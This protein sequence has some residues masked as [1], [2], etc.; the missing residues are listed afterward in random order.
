MHAFDLESVPAAFDFKCVISSV[1]ELISS[2]MR[3][4]AW[5]HRLQFCVV[6]VASSLCVVCVPPAKML[7]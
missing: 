7:C 6:C 4:C 1:I 3:V 2:V 5:V